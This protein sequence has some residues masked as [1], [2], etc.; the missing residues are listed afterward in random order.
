MP[1]PFTVEDLYLHRRINSLHCVAGLD[2]AV[3]TVSS[4]DR[5]GDAQRTYLWQFPL[6]GSGGAE[7]AY[8]DGSDSSP[9]W[10]PRGDRLAFLSSRSGTT[11]VYVAPADAHAGADAA[12]QVGNLPSGVMNLRWLP[13]GSGLI[14]TAAVA[15]DPD[16]HGA[17]STRPPPPRKRGA[18]RSSGGCRTRKTAPATCCSEKSISTGSTSP[19]ARR[20]G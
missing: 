11:Q 19:P 16:L 18:P 14:V 4:I 3:C 7:L 10:S 17:R 15:V 9:R 12:E 2:R 8:S 5:E 20:N 1:Q 6:D 13:D